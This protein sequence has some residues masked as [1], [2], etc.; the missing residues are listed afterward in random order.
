[1]SYLLTIFIFG[2][3]I[4][5]ALYGKKGFNFFRIILCSI[6]LYVALSCWIIVPVFV[7]IIVLLMF[8]CYIKKK[9]KKESY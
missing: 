9:D 6:I 5:M 7:L 8:F 2:T 4:S 3:I 1:M